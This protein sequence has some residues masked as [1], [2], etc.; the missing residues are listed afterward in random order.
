MAMTTERTAAALLAIVAIGLA[1]GCV[2]SEAQVFDPVAAGVEARIGQPVTWRHASVPPP[3]VRRTIDEL[4]RRPL[5]ADRAARIALLASPALQAELDT[6][7]VSAAELARA[8]ALPNPEIDAALRLPLSETSRTEVDLDA[9]L[10]VVGLIKAAARRRA[11]SAELEA[12]RQ[13]AVGATI[14]VAAQARI[15]YYRAAADQQMVAALG[16]VTAAAEASYDLARRLHA[17]GNITDLTLSQ[18]QALYEQTRLDLAQARGA[19]VRSR[20]ALNR[21]LGLWGGQTG[22]RTSPLAEP[23][24]ALRSLA[25]LERDAIGK[26]LELEAMRWDMRAAGRTVGVARLGWLPRLGLGVSAARDADGWGLGPAM[27]LSLPLFN[28]GQGERAAAW[29]RLRQ[30]RSRYADWAVAIRAAARTIAAE[31]SEAHARARDLADT[32]VPLRRHIVEQALLEYNAMQLSPFELLL[33]K[34]QEIDVQR[35]YIESVRD[36]WVAATRLAALRAGRLVGAAPVTEMPQVRAR[37][38]TGAIH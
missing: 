37:D 34:Q 17:A 12:A 2:P 36:Y 22:W 11:S 35:R 10:D 33:A 21:T 27:V 38:V 9:V 32:L 30:A 14:A 23:P 5:D 29:A 26:S 7:G 24:R 1:S 16:K 4:L 6:L 15:G 8:G 3:E 28:N 20:Q 13:R 31:V 19:A 18:E 25:R